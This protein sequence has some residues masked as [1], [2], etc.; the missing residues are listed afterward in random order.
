M[1]EMEEELAY[2]RRHI[3][4]LQGLGRGALPYMRG[5]ADG[6]K[7]RLEMEGQFDQLYGWRVMAGGTHWHKNIREGN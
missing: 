7:A 6:K 1:N 3:Q 2:I 4:F 5:F